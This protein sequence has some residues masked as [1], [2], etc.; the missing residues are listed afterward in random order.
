M[1]ARFRLHP[2]VAIMTALL[3]FNVGA[4]AQ[5][6]PETRLAAGVRKIETACS[7][8]LKKYCSE[9]T[10]GDERLMLCIQAHEDKI[11]IQCDYAL[12]EASRN[13]NRALDRIA[14][15]ADV[16]WSD[17]ERLCSHLPEGGWRIARCLESQRV[18]L[19]PACQTQ[20]SASGTAA[21]QEV[22]PKRIKIESDPPNNPELQQVYDLLKQR[23][24][25]EKAQEFFGIFKLPQ[26]ITI[27]ARSCGMSNAW[28]VQGTVTI[29]YEYLDD[30]LKSMPEETT[31][32]GIT[33]ADAV[34]G[35][36]AYTLAHEM[37]HALF[38]ILD[39]PLLGAPEDAADEFAAYMMLQLGKDQARRFILGAA[40]S[41]ANYL[42]NPKVIVNRQ[43]FAD[44]HGAP[45]QRYYDLMC[46]AYGADREAFQDLV[47]KGYL[48][49][50][51]ARSC[52]MEYGEANF[53][54]KKL[55]EPSIDQELAEK[56]LDKNW[57]PDPNVHLFSG[58]QTSVPSST[59][60]PPK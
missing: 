4:S 53:A 23:Q 11:S 27:V 22:R 15:I 3:V 7:N 12:F 25:L 24:W 21:A 48:P 32:E 18:I 49:D 6:Q 58:G 44:S 42:K 26:D 13:L 39:I 60:E 9:V 46:M 47:D 34:I 1:A 45:L 55:I 41:Y 54:Y 31:P 5:S 16:C 8:D 57:L 14:Q 37:G 30:I 29:C 52:R 19:T 36:F 50:A 43:A 38:D 59:T 35:Q 28:Y 33:Q 20:F 51:R 10:P 40:Y 2:I 56:V 17:I